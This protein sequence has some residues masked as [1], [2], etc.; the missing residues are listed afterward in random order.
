M[1]KATSPK[2]VT[3]IITAIQAYSETI[4][5]SKWLVQ[6]TVKMFSDSAVLENADEVGHFLTLISTP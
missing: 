6:P 5:N 1:L 3:D 2:T 4:T